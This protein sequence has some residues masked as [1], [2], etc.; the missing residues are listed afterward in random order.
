MLNE[1]DALRIEKNKNRAYVEVEKGKREVESEY[2]KHKIEQE[3]A[4]EKKDAVNKFKKSKLGIAL[5]IW[6]VISA[7]FC[8]V[9]FGNGDVL[10]GF[11]AVAMVA[12]AVTS[13]L[14]G[15]QIVTEKKKGCK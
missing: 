14:M 9:S 5:I 10:S 3:K 1:S 13:W 15:A 2:L 8:L 4:Q 11:I 6:T 12:L 7:F